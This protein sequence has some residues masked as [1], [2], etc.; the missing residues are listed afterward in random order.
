M[1]QEIKWDELLQLAKEKGIDAIQL[2]W[3]LDVFKPESDAVEFAEWLSGE[4]Y[5]QY[6]SKERWIVPHINYTVYFTEQLYEQ[7][8]LQRF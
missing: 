2:R 1:T 3:I 6:D 4:G 8:L 7:F 5:Q